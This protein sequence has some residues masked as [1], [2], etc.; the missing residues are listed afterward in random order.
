MTNEVKLIN[1]NILFDTPTQID[2]LSKVSRIIN[3]HLGKT[4]Q[5]SDVLTAREIT[6]DF[7]RGQEIQ[8]LLISNNPSYTKEELFDKNY[9]ELNDDIEST[10]LKVEAECTQ[11]NE[12]QCKIATSTK[13]LINDYCNN[14][15][16][17]SFLISYSHSHT[18]KHKT[19]FC[20]ITKS[21]LY[22][23]VEESL[24]YIE[25]DC[26]VQLHH[27]R[28]NKPQDSLDLRIL[29]GMLYPDFKTTMKTN[30][31]NDIA[32]TERSLVFY[33]GTYDL[34]KD[35]QSIALTQ[36]EG[37]QYKPS[38]TFMTKPLRGTNSE[39]F[40]DH[41][42]N[43]ADTFHNN[44]LNNVGKGL[45]PLEIDC[46]KKAEKLYKAISMVSPESLRAIQPLHTYFS[47][48][49]NLQMENIPNVF[50]SS[51]PPYFHSTSL[52]LAL[53]IS[54]EDY[55]CTS[56]VFKTYTD[57][58][59]QKESFPFLLDDE[60]TTEVLDSLFTPNPTESFEFQFYKKDE[61]SSIP[62][63]IEIKLK[64]T[65]GIDSKDQINLESQIGSSL[66]KHFNFLERDF[67]DTKNTAEII[68]DATNYP[69]VHKHLKDTTLIIAE[70]LLLESSL[71][72]QQKDEIYADCAGSL[73]LPTI[74]LTDEL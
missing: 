3:A 25:N 41:L 73:A 28:H 43:F 16:I 8:E 38:R 58:N 19:N 72:A 61:S 11:G 13:A 53:K 35:V 22:N 57:F 71:N 50:E 69:A 14:P 44:F 27:F 54:K 6:N 70:E 46:G 23:S 36:P 17:K 12:V 56:K 29:D 65:P 62:Y 37:A 66:L 5:C 1:T 33:I 74:H 63:F 47:F 45:Q 40:N 30:M 68:L 9:E 32:L 15:Q 31:L 26:I 55:R 51:I 49:D 34:S 52:R 64:T 20:A 10:L 4:E 39:L 59:Q 42:E 48:G 7:L 67:K 24:S 18:Y 21:K 2:Y 60:S